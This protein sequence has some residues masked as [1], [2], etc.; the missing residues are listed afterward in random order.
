MIDKAV[1]AAGMGQLGGAFGREVDGAVSAMYYSVLSPHLSDEQFVDAVKQVCGTETFWPAPAVILETAGV[2]PQQRSE[3][4]LRAVN[5]ALLEHGGY[6]FLPAAISQSWDAATW[7]AIKEIGGLKEITECTHE[8]WPKLQARFRRA[9]EAAFA[10]KPA[11][12][13]GEK[14]D[15]RVKKLV[16]ETGRALALPPRDR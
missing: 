15:P 5:D 1:F 2:S 16:A 9:Y 11:L 12:P 3:G 14:P 4:A 13:S 8:R 10:L 6:R 7:A